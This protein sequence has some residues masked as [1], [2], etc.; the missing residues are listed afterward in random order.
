MCDGL[1]HLG[2]VGICCDQ[3]L[4]VLGSEPVVP[5]V[6]EVFEDLGASYEQALEVARLTSGET[7]GESLKLDEERNG[8]H[9]FWACHLASTSFSANPLTAQSIHGS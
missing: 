9:F 6:E 2:D 4:E 7:F 8:T 5:E 1:S 3:I